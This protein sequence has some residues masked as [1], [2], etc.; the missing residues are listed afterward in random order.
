[1]KEPVPFRYAVS[2]MALLALLFLV[3]T[4]SAAVR[5]EITEEAFAA[6]AKKVAPDRTTNTLVTTIEFPPQEA[7]IVRLAIRRTDGGQ[8][9][10]DELG[11]KAEG[12]DEAEVGRGV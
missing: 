9:C 2:L 4:A 5:R 3:P 6:Y 12:V 11:A 10:L 8:P 1:M 7:R